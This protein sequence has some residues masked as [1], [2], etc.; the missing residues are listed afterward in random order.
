MSATNYNEGQVK[1]SYVFAASRQQIRHFKL[2]QTAQVG[3]RRPK[4]PINQTQL[5]F[6]D[7]QI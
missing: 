7:C 6:N 5:M 2:Q 3:E 1:S 4:Q